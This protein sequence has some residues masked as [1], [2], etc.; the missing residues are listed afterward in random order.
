MRGSASGTT[1]SRGLAS[2]PAV[3]LAGVAHTLSFS[4]FE[5]W[6]LQLLSLGVLAHATRDAAPR[7]AAWLGWLFAVGWLVSGFWWLYISMHRYGGMNPALAASAVLL[8]AGLLGLYYAAAMALWARL[9]AGRPALDLLLWSACW[10]AAELA[11]GL[12]FTGFPWIASGYAHTVGPLAASAPWIGVYGLCALAA[13][14]A[15]TLALWLGEAPQRVRVRCSAIVVGVVLAAHALPHRFTQ[16]TGALSVSLLQPNVSQDLKFDPQRLEAQLSG[17]V[18]QLS[19]SRG[20]LVVTPESV[21]PLTRAQL[22]DGYWDT[23]Q[24]ALQGPASGAA[25]ARA[26]RAALIGLFVGDDTTGYVN[27]LVGLPA[28]SS[29]AASADIAEY[30]YGKRHLLPFGE[31]IPPGFHWFVDLMNIPLAD[32]ARGRSIAALSFGG[33]R[34]RPLV[35]YE[36]LF[37]EDIVASVVGPQAATVFV[38]VSNLAWFGRLLVQDQHLQFSQMRAIEFERPVIRSTNTGATAVVDHRGNVTARLPPSIEGVL[39][40]SVEGRLGET[41]YARWLAAFG[42][43]PLVVAVLAVVGAAA[44]VRRGARGPA[45][46]RR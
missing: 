8:L 33:Q 21:L 36:D 3:L 38:N 35:C 31:I 11:R 37:G 18:R 1:W 17:L 19:T 43:W 2:A 32:Q 20:A 22:S 40:T 25:A 42:L 9:R 5:W 4:P 10:L 23:L 46:P 7:R 29:A 26:P 13:A 39:E 30:R 45:A 27:S 41:P 44:S 12:I 15:C 16:S 6:W 24:E 28:A 14:L 34:L